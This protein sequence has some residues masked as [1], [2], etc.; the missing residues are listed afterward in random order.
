MRTP[1]PAKCERPAPYPPTPRSPSAKARPLGR[2]NIRQSTPGPSAA[3]W[4][5]PREPLFDPSSP[6][7]SELEQ[8][9]LERA[10]VRPV[11]G[12]AR[13]PSNSI[14]VDDSEEERTFYPA[15]FDEQQAELPSPASMTSEST[16]VVPRAAGKHRPLQK[17]PREEVSD[18][19]CQQPPKA[20]DSVFGVH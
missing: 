4:K 10:G 18:C 1:P 7:D 9:E 19:S 16:A 2:P 15:T 8:D 11:V 13:K 12:R 5:G 14:E 17:R 20:D 3:P 6:S